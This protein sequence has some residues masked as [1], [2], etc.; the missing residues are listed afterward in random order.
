MKKKKPKPPY[1]ADAAIRGALRKT[2]ARSP[3]VIAA[4]RAVRRE[5][6]R[7][8][9]DG[10]SA[11]RPHVQY[12]C[13]VCTEWHSSTKVSVDHVEPVI[14]TDEGFK[15][16]NTFVERLFCDSNNLQVICETCHKT[17]TYSERVDRLTKQYS[18]DLDKIT[19]AA[20]DNPST[21]P[22]LKEILLTYIAKKKVPA[23]VAVGCRAEELYNILS[24]A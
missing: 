24:G 16:W 19:D 1:N 3:A 10:T 2:F 17:K 4:L 21:I 12:Q 20:L 23:F 7:V 8:K 14:S 22:Q 13:A 5:M 15:D 18:A 11:K 9:L 6:P